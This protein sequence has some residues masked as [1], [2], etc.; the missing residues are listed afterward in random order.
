MTHWDGAVAGVAA[1]PALEADAR[2]DG[3]DEGDC[4]TVDTDRL[5][6]KLYPAAWNRFA[7][8]SVPGRAH[9]RIS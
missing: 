7:K 3:F 5:Y 1:R 9:E 4:M 2:R 8:R 6:E